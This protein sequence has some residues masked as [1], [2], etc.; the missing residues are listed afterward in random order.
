MGKR[1]KCRYCDELAVAYRVE[2]DGA[3]T[4]ICAFHIP[5]EEDE[6]LSELREAS[7]AKRDGA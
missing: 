7:D 6:R 3:K 5:V 2:A 4:P 1:Q